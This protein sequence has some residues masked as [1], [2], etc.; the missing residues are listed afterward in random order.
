MAASTYEKALQIAA[1]LPPEDQQRL[2]QELTSRVSRSG[3]AESKH[4]IMEL[5]GLGKEIWQGIDAQEYVRNERASW[6]G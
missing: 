5:C 4:S 3:P 6:D 2:I 1:S